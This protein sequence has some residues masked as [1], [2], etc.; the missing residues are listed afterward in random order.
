MSLRVHPMMP[1]ELQL[2]RHG[3]RQVEMAPGY[4][5]LH[6]DG[7]S[8]VFGVIRQRQPPRSGASP[9]TTQPSS[10]P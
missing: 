4:V 7:H 8:L 10:W 2:A 3:F 5:Y 6:P 1:Q 9:S